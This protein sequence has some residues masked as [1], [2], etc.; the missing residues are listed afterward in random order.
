MQKNRR[1]IRDLTEI[2]IVSALLCL[3][4]LIYIPFAVPIT[5]Q[6]LVLFLSLFTLGGRR[7]SI[8]TAVYIAIGA[9]GVPV[10]SGFSGGIARLFDATGGYIFGLLLGAICFWILEKIMPGNSLFSAVKAGASL[11]MIYLLGTSW[12]AFVYLKGEGFGYLISICVL[13]F[14]IPDVVKIY[15]AYIISKRVP[16]PL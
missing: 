6:T 11:F 1:H 12:Y 7:T 13:P 14:I 2:A 16:K 8:A 4:A 9:L 15:I 3:S 10:F 5:L